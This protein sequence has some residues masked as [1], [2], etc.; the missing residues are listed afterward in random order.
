MSGRE[1]IVHVR[2][3]TLLGMLDDLDAGRYEALR[4]TLARLLDFE[5]RKQLSVA[6]SEVRDRK[7]AAAERGDEKAVQ[8]LRALEELIRTAYTE[9]RG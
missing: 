1:P 8:E 4:E 3:S 7:V 6:F 5:R 2:K 9:V